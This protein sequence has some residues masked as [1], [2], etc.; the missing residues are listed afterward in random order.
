MK[1]QLLTAHC[2]S[3]AG[4]LQGGAMPTAAASS[5]Q[6]GWGGNVAKNNYG[7]LKY[8]PGCAEG[9]DGRGQQQQHE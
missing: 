3:M 6:G 1:L 9:A 8:V 7:L 2:M 4:P 5:E